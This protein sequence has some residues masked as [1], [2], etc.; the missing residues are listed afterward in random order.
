MNFVIT[1]LALVLYLWGVIGSLFADNVVLHRCLSERNNE[2]YSFSFTNNP[3]A[4]LSYNLPLS[5][6]L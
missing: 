5:I 2:P 4:K 6:L 3:N 1:L